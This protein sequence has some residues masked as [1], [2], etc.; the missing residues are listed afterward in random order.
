MDFYSCLR[1][2]W[3]IFLLFG[4][5]TLLSVLGYIIVWLTGEEK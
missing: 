4:G 2:L 1:V 3:G 5:L